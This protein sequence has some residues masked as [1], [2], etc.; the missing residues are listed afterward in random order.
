MPPVTWGQIETGANIAIGVILVATSL[1]AAGHVLL[2]KRDP[3]AALGWMGL[4]LI[5][6]FFG[7]LLYALIGI[8][9]V[10]RRALAWTQ[11]GKRVA[12]TTSFG[13]AAITAVPEGAFPSHLLELRNL[14][15]TVTRRTILGGNAI[16]PLFDGE[17]AYPEMLAAIGGASR[18]IDLATYIF[19]ADV[20]GRRFAGALL[21]AAARGVDVRVLVDGMGEKY[22][23]PHARS[24]FRHSKVRCERFLPLRHGATFN[25]RNHRKIL[26]VDGTRAFTGGMN[27]SDRHMVGMT[28][29]SGPVHDLH[30]RVDGPVVD[31][32]RRIFVEDWF[33]ATGEVR[34]S[35]RIFQPIAAA[36]TAAARAI[37]DG[38]DEVTRKLHWILMGALACASKRVRIMTPYFI[39][40]RS[41]LAALGTAALRGVDVQLLLPEENNLPFV[42][43]A[44]RGYLTEL[45]EFGIEVRY[46][47]PPFVH[48]KLFLVDDIWSL[49]GSA[50]LDPRSLRLNFELNLEVYDPATAA[51]LAAHFDESFARSRPVTAAE[52]AALPL[53]ARLRDAGAKL[54]SPYL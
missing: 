34:E 20:T 3:R 52:L 13:P 43:W 35:D 30:F 11:T 26:V 36:G 47:P 24:L 32:V 27:I 49:I 4:C 39:P 46:Q 31:D 12:S 6:P 42:G 29:R 23:W 48:T 28:S 19:D 2:Y 44:S 25:L 18:S 21:A 33:F 41:Q 10:R 50:N 22:S 53:A 5:L 9:R 15:D 1:G 54:F 7:P 45:L 40:S 14:A 8:N 51:R 16:E 17:Q 37:D 38:P